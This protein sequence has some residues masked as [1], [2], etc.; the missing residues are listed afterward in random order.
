M[1]AASREL[2]FVFAARAVNAE[3]SQPAGESIVVGHQ[4]AAVSEGAE[5]FRR[6]EAEAADASDT[7]RRAPAITRAERL[8]GVFYHRHTAAIS[9]RLQFFEICGHAEQ[10]HG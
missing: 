3:L 8:R 9:E 1:I 5:R 2:V 7:P 6:M 4:H 10:V